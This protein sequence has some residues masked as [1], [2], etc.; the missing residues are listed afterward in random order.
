MTKWPKEITIPDRVGRGAIRNDDGS[1]CCAVGH[2]EY[3]AWKLRPVRSAERKG[4]PLLSLSGPI[5]GAFQDQYRRAAM[6]LTGHDWNG[7]VSIPCINDHL[8]TNYKR[9]LVYCTAWAL[10][11]YTEG[12]P[13][14]VLRLMRKVQKKGARE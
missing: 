10:L 13:R 12:M 5:W 9:V 8:P 2:F 11:G 7:R 1:P 4:K 6:G 14:S 3:E